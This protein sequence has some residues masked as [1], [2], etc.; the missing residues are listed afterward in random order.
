VTERRQLIR[1][2]S[3][4]Y[5]GTVI[6]AGEFERHVQIWDIES[7]TR[8]A[9]FETTL[10]FGGTRLAISPNGKSCAVGAYHVHGIALYDATNGTE[11]WRRKD[12][13][14]VQKIRASHDGSRLLCGFEGKAFQPLNMDNG[15]SKPSLRGVQDIFES[16]YDDLMIVD[17]IGK[18]FKLVNN[19]QQQVATVPRT[20]FAA[21]DFAFAPK[22][23]AITESGGSISCYDV[24]GGGKLWEHNPGNGVHALDLTYNESSGTFA[25]ITWPYQNGGQHQLLNLL[26]ETGK[27]EGAFPIDGAHEFAFCSK[28]STLI[29]SDGKLRNTATGDVYGTIPFFP[30]SND[31]T[32]LR[33]LLESRR[34]AKRISQ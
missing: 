11:L 21:L 29:S 31:A 30:S 2:I 8:I 18:D 6:A 34:L 22:K 13:K 27:T 20:T 7:Q 12:L 26:A 3:T 19:N 9:E 15:R 16:V 10:D 32:A 25:A 24:N 23:I 5:A 33:A 14:K 28:G 4:S 17:R 1:H